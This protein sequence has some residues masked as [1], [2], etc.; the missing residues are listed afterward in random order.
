MEAKDGA[1]IN[2]LRCGREGFGKTYSVWADESKQDVLG[3]TRLKQGLLKS[4]KVVLGA[5]SKAAGFKST[6]ACLYVLLGATFAV[7]GSMCVEC[8]LVP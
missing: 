2:G 8:S 1:A 4:R 6:S 5:F 3:S 7:I